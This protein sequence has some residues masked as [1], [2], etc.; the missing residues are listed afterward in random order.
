MNVPLGGTV[1]AIYGYGK[2]DNEDI[3]LLDGAILG[4][5]TWAS[6]HETSLPILGLEKAPDKIPFKIQASELVA[7][8][9]FGI[10]TEVVRGYVNDQLRKKD[11]K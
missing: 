8:V 3:N 11:N 7:H 4:A 6:T 2:R 10:T 1:G 9:V 5:T